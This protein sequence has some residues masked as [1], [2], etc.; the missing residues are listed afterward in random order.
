M[1]QK[2]NIAPGPS[3][4]ADCRDLARRFDYDR[5]MATLFVHRHARPVLWTLLAFN[6]E[7]ARTR[8]VVSEPM[9]GQIRLQ[10]WREVIDMALAGGPVREH[11]VVKP[12]TWAIREQRLEPALLLDMIEARE[13]DLD[14][15]PLADKAAL[16]D[17]VE[18]TAGSLSV[19]MARAINGGDRP[20]ADGAAGAL[21]RGWALVGVLRSARF[22]AGRG[23]QLIP[24]SLLD[25]AGAGPRDLLNGRASDGVRAAVRQVAEMARRELQSAQRT[26]A[27]SDRLLVLK[28]V[29]TAY[30][31]RFEQRRFDPFAEGTEISP[32]RL[33]WI[34][35][36]AHWFRRGV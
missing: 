17:Y 14:P 29:A 34:M 15:A 20:L 4:A 13:R 23:Q 8:E 24:K 19:A 3:G 10:W 9:I 35:L 25:A 36:A 26:G 30:L 22:H 31:R 2:G 21:G 27:P 32:S 12:L 1:T 18:G 16:T 33:Q 5:F 28:S 7:V 6:A 11:P